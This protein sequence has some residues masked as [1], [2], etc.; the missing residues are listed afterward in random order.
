MS[1]PKI[2]ENVNVKVVL[3]ASKV[4]FRRYPAVMYPFY[5]YLIYK[6]LL[7]KR[8]RFKIITLPDELILHIFHKY[9][10][11][12]NQDSNKCVIVPKR[13]ATD[14]E[15][16]DYVNITDDF[17]RKLVQIFPFDIPGDLIY[18]SETLRHNL[19]KIN[20]KEPVRLTPI[21]RASIGIAKEVEIRLI[22]SGNEIS[23]HMCD[24]LLKNYFRSP[25]LV[26]KND[27]L[28]VNVKQYAPEFIY[29]NYKTNSVE[30][31]YFKYVRIKSDTNEDCTGSYFCVKGETE[32]R[33]SAHVQDYLPA[34]FKRF[35]AEKFKDNGIEQAVINRCPYGFENRLDNLRKAVKPFLKRRK[36]KLKPV[37]LIQGNK[38][39]AKNLLVSTLADELGFNFYKISSGD[40]SATAYSQTEIK[41]KNAFFKAKLCAPCLFVINNFENFGKTHD[42]K[43]NERIVD[44]FKFELTNNLTN[45]D[46]PLIV[47]CISNSKDV[48]AELSRIFLEV[49]EFG[50]PDQD[51]RAKILEWMLEERALESDVDMNEIAGKTHGFFYGDLAALVY[52][53]H[54]NGFENRTTGLLSLIKDDFDVALGK[55]SRVRRSISDL[56]EFRSRR[57][58]ADQLC[59]Q[60]GG[61]ESAEGAMV[62]R[63]WSGRRQGRNN[64]DDQ[65]TVEAP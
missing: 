54:K 4:R 39:N 63:R 3:Y 32:L 6:F 55:C 47:I 17:A 23:N 11:K 37:F 29:N 62:G 25:K 24:I 18:M 49:F 27:V 38:G 16:D 65:P 46:P 1:T 59:G 26:Q 14:I 15:L 40:V 33:Q 9:S 42:G 35:I 41:I 8:K 44:Y 34:K 22:S 5:M 60:Y 13:F 45:N 64:P 58:H 7:K 53:A 19:D 2:F 30:N 20:L 50:A 21:D 52:Y 57:Y 48:P 43:F 61:A 56:I 28:S 31:V 10:I 12:S 51:D 36:I